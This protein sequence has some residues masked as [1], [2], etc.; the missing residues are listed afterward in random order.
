MA[1]NSY[2]AH[3]GGYIAYGPRTIPN[4][5]AGG[6]VGDYPWVG[7]GAEKIESKEIV[8]NLADD[9][10][11]NSWTASTTEGTIKAAPTNPDFELTGIDDNFDYLFISK[12]YTNYV[13][14]DNATKIKI[15]TSGSSFYY[16]L[17]YFYYSNYGEFN[18]NTPSTINLT[19]IGNKTPLVYYNSSGVK[20][21]TTNTIGIYFSSPS[22]Y[23]SGAGKIAYK[24]SAI[25]ARCSTTY[26]DTARKSDIDASKTELVAEIDVYKIPKDNFYY[27]HLFEEVR[28]YMLEHEA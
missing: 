17:A 3:S 28:E 25:K 26:F 16:D 4:Q 13:L 21:F 10:T 15:P 23:S 9:T 8:Y 2:I 5:P 12:F 6:S 22:V 11:W 19:S 14:T 18:S 7:V 1:T 24:L 27:T 20:T